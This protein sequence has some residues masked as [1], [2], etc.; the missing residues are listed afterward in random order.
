MVKAYLRYQERDVFGIVASTVANLASDIDGRLAVTPALQ[1]VNVWDTKKAE[2]VSSWHDPDNTSHEVSCITRA[3]NG[4]DYAVGYT[5]GSV[6]IWTMPA[7]ILHHQS[8]PSTIYVHEPAHWFQGHSGS[9]TALAF[10]ASGTILAS[11]SQDTNIVIWDVVA[12]AGTARL[13]GHKDQ[14]TCLDFVSTAAAMNTSSDNA[15]DA[16]NPA[17]P[18]SHLLSGS[19]DTTVKA[20]DLTTRACVET[21]V[22]HRS[23][24]WALCVT[25]MWQDAAEGILTVISAGDECKVHKLDCRVLAS[26]LDAPTPAEEGDNDAAD[27]A[28]VSTPAR[29]LVHAADL[30]K[31]STQ[32]ATS[33]ALSPCGGYLVL[34]CVDTQVQILRFLTPEE[35]KGKLTRRRRKV[36]EAAAKAGMDPEAAVA[37]AALSVAD[38]IAPLFLAVAS[39][40]VRSVAMCPGAASSNASAALV[41]ARGKGKAA[42]PLFSFFATRADNAVEVFVVTKDEVQHGSTVDVPGHRG[43][44][45]AIALSPDDEMLVTGGTALVKVWN[46]RNGTCVRSMEAGYALCVAFVPGGKFILVGT[47]A[48]ELQIF[49]IASSELVETIKAHDSAIWSIAVLP[50]KTGFITGSADHEVKFWDFA[51]VREEASRVTAMHTRTLKLADE[52]LCVCVSPNQKL[53]AVSLLDATVKVFYLDSLKFALSLYGHKLP[54]LCM[55]ISSDSALILTGSADKNIKVWGLDFGDCHRS[56]FAHGEAVMQAK[57]VWGTHYAFTVSKDRQVKYWDLD[58]YACISTLAGH[59]GEIWALAIGKFGSF[60]AT[61]AHDR[62]IRIWERTD[63]QMLLQDEK[64]R[65]L[66]DQA[67]EA[68]VSAA[69]DTN[70]DGDAGV[71]VANAESL[72]AGERIVEALEM[73]ADAAEKSALALAAG[74]PEPALPPL[75][76]A[77]GIPSA[78]AYVLRAVQRVRPADLEAAL[79]V[80]PSAHVPLLLEL[81]HDWARTGGSALAAACR[82]LFFVLRVHHHQLVAARSLRPLLQKLQTEVRGA[83]ERQRNMVGTNMAGFKYLKREKE[84]TTGA[85]F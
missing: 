17:G 38:Q 24:V 74:E 23:E 25:S 60:V 81:A 58:K 84:L 40:K 54:V 26:I 27:V 34:A 50:D 46:V 75:L 29:A 73:C 31:H 63:E 14:V 85:A 80:V 76:V 1:R 20:W 72:K 6:R 8:V 28:T 53:V 19:K 79:L 7:P 16:R 51:L 64:N 77:M 71:A 30:K 45:R 62:S 35:S 5:D 82:V 13:T 48:G 4:K 12:G 32:R 69:N 57:W 2:L 56:L 49:S 83:I 41:A 9:V 33:L 21:V 52:V 36:R 15:S 18:A 65:E 3:P 43:D 44:I 47:K 66:D 10:D 70:A 67:D 68:L 78:P 22:T 37:A 55:D 61:A 11:G 42:M 39:A 59:V